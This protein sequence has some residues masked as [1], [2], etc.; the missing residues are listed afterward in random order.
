LLRIELTK[1]V[2]SALRRLF[3]LCGA[4]QVCAGGILM[5]QN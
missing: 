5:R 2:G 3:S 4:G 1:I